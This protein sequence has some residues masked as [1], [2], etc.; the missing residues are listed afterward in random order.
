MK[1]YTK[2]KQSELSS[3]AASVVIENK[4]HVKSSAARVHPS[5]E[6]ILLSD[7]GCLN[8]RISMHAS[9]Y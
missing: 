4:W 3:V 2:G 8:E 1:C 5:D 6:S 7:T 9:T